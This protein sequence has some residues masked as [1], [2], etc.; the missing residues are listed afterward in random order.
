[1]AFHTPT[2]LATAMSTH[3]HYPSFARV[4]PAVGTFMSP[5]SLLLRQFVVDVRALDTEYV[6]LDET[7]V[8]RVDSLERYCCG[9][10]IRKDGNGIW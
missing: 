2:Y 7:I 4:L 8:V 3:L 1:M 10:F 5:I 9:K 6:I